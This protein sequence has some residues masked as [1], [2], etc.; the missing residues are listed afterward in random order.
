MA[1]GR[2]E[3]ERRQAAQRREAERRAREAARLAKENER[4]RQRRHLEK[5]QAAAE[6]KTAKVA[7]RIEEI[8]QILVSV[9]RVRPLA[10]DQMKAV[11]S[12][13]PFDPG[14]MGVA[15]RPPDW[16]QFAPPTPS[17]LSKIF[18]GQSRYE[19]SLQEARGRFDNEVAQHRKREEK[20]LRE[21]DAARAAYDRQIA[22]AMDKAAAD[23]AQLDQL[24]TEFDNGQPEAVEWFAAKVL[25][26]SVYP[27]DFPR[28]YQVAYRPENHDLVVEFELPPQSA[29]PDVRGYKYVKARDDIDPVPRPQT[30]V[31]QRYAKL[32]ACVALRTLHEIF[33]A[34]PGSIIE[35][36]V[37]NGRLNT[38][39]QATGKKVRP[40]LLSVQAERVAFEEFVLADVN[41]VACLKRLNA[42]VSPNPYDLEA[43]EPFIAFDLKRFRFSADM[44]VV[45]GLDSR[46]DLLK[47]TPTEFEHLVR[48]LFIA[49]GA[50]AWTTIPSKDGGV[51][52]VATSNNLFF[53]G[54][55]L[56]QAKRWAGLVGL[57]AVH[58]LTGV[59]ADHN[60][61]TGV[62]VTTSWFGRASEQFAQRNRITLINGAELKHLIKQYL[63]IDVIP[64]T[65]PPRNARASDNTQS[66]RPG[67]D[68]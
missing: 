6:Q 67:P 24:R 66:G 20:R 15:E 43:I 17:G 38:I 59:M 19:R 31:K 16:G 45:A 12:T 36:I 21:L 61:T 42:L 58:A 35:A 51:D 68:A 63:N 10:F 27:K 28:L 1:G 30:E 3:W 37:F 47:L 56:I 46:R 53:G 39:D 40:H 26:G 11:P 55:C 4:E 9:L 33:A 13:Q 22:A 41:P 44:D 23:N 49:M 64:G 29:I 57:D 5:Q 8:D 25:D 60:A 50:E 48:E 54:V 18:G 32:L 62:L 2:S 52:A 65:T 14:R 34:T 7:K